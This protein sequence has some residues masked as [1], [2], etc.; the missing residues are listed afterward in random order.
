MSP[1]SLPI[2]IVTGLSGAG[3][4]TALHVLEDLDYYCVDNL[5]PSLAPELI[6]LAHSQ[7]SVPGLAFGVDVRTGTFLTGAAALVDS[8]QQSGHP[9]CVLF[10]ECQDEVLVRRYSETRRPHPLA[11]RGDRWSAI[12]QERS[13]L[14]D[15]RARAAHV[16]DT[17]RMSI[18]DLR[19]D[20]VALLAQG[21]NSVGMTTRILSFGFKYGLPVDADLVFDLR[22]L[23]NPHFDAALRPKTGLDAEVRHFVLDAALTQQT[24][25]HL[26]GLLDFLLPRYQREGKSYLTVAL[27]CT[28]GKHR[29]VACATAL[30]APEDFVGSWVVEHR[31]LHRDRR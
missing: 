11:E 15:L 6:E 21:R 9:V 22:F 18:H 19:R 27:G 3:R 13:R 25:Q 30:A 20:L 2:V 5:P 14:S 10:L 4:S 31:D 8:L 28:G 26:Q 29:S 24:L 23:P 16:I 17:S 1:P 7:M 12:Q